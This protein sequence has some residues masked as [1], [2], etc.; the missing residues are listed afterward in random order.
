MLT[1]RWAL[2][3][4]AVVG[5]AYACF[6]LGEWQFHRLQETKALNAVVSHNLKAPPVPL[7][8][9]MSVGRPVDPAHQWQR[10]RATGRYVADQT[11]T[12][13]YQTRN[14]QTGVDVVTPLRT[15][16]G[17]ALLVDRGWVST[18]NVGTSRPQVPPPPGGTVTVVGWVRIS[19]TGDA[20]AVDD[21]STRAISSAAIAPILPFPVYGGFVDALSETPKPAHPLVSAEM[22]DLGNGPHFFYG[23]Q[24]WFFAA[25]AVFGFIYLAWDE[26]RKR[27]RAD[28][29]DPA[30]QPPAEKVDSAP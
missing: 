22:P 29:E 14:G 24:W 25:L 10:V 20:T 21:H 1:R 9:V 3:A 27:P 11:V 4:V 15:R 5:L 17:A 16:S 7:D 19:A 13:R 28:G 18:P 8:R 23:V 12:V 2:F 26:R 6:R 30:A